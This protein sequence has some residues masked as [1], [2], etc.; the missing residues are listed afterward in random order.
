MAGSASS[1][2]KSS[3][4]G[5]GAKS[6]IMRIRSYRSP[7]APVISLQS[8]PQRQSAPGGLSSQL[9]WSNYD[10]L[11]YPYYPNSA[12]EDRTRRPDMP[13]QLLDGWRISSTRQRPSRN[14]YDHNR[15]TTN[16]H[17]RS[18]CSGANSSRIC[19]SAPAPNIS[20][21][22]RSPSPGCTLTACDASIST[23]VAKP[24]L[25]ASSTVARTQ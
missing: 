10:C 21:R 19:G 14:P 18:H 15:M 17:T 23:D 8:V 1:S 9:N 4:T 6:G 13:R 20:L 12:M 25:R 7:V 5:T 11:A 24:L 16:E 22:A 3:G 2:C